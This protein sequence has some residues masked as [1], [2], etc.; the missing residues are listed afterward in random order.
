MTNLFW[1]ALVQHE[2]QS[3]YIH[4]YELAVVVGNLLGMGGAYFLGPSLSFF[5]ICI[6][7]D[8]ED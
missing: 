8:Y 7:L 2:G 3:Q 1:Y 4:K 5:I 6:A